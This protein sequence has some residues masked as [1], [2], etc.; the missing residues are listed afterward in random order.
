MGIGVNTPIW[1]LAGGGTGRTTGV[2]GWAGYLPPHAILWSVRVRMGKMVTLRGRTVRG[3]TKGPVFSGGTLIQL[4]IP[5]VVRRFL[6]LDMNVTS[7]LVMA[8][9][10]RTTISNISLISGVGVLLVRV[11]TTLSANNTIIISRCLNDNGGS[12]TRES[13]GRLVCAAAIFSAIVVVLTLIFHH[14]ILSLIFNGVRPSIVRD[15]LIC[16]LAATVTCPF[17]TV[18]G[19][20]TTLFHSIKGDGVS[21][22]GSLVIG[23]IGVAM[24]TI[25]VC[26]FGVNTLNTNVKALASHVITTIFVLIL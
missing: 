12:T 1:G 20:N 9:T 25:L 6:L 2:V 11:F 24:G 5:L 22:L 23:V 7:A 10:N 19:T 16:F 21:V 13:T 15:T 18:C 26:N 17:V 3:S 14:R 4:V 8:A